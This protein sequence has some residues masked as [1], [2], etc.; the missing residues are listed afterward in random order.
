MEYFCR[1][2]GT[3]LIDLCCPVCGSKYR[4]KDKVESTIQAGMLHNKSPQDVIR[5]LKM[6]EYISSGLWIII[7]VVQ[8]MLFAFLVIGMCNIILAIVSLIYTIT[9]IKPY[10]Y[11]VYEYYKNRIAHI[12]ICAIVN[13]LMGGVIGIIGCIYDL[14]IRNYVLKNK[15]AFNK[16]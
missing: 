5:T 9:Q 10:Q 16:I 12:V 3:K 1:K 6:H 8:I 13:L 15:Y 14:F 7:G 11:D 4:V 2:C